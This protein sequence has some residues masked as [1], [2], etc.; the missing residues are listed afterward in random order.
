MIGRSF[1]VLILI[2]FLS[3]VFGS[4][5]HSTSCCNSPFWIIPGDTCWGY[6]QCCGGWDSISCNGEEYCTGPSHSGASSLPS[7]GTECSFVWPSKEDI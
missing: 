1:L 2:A 4:D 5:K 7:P 6:T 3:A